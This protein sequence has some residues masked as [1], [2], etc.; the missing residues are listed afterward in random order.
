LFSRRDHRP[1][2][3]NSLILD[4]G[5]V[6]ETLKITVGRSGEQELKLT[7]G[8]HFSGKNF[9]RYLDG[10]IGENAVEHDGRRIGPQVTLE[11]NALQKQRIFLRR[12]RRSLPVDRGG[13]AKQHKYED[14][15]ECGEPRV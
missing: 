15:P 10:I 7:E 5:K 8:A 14:R 1:E 3:K 13:A 4:R 6:D 12:S 9:P 2:I 11:Y